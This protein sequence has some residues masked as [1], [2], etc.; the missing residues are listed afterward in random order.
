MIPP[1]EG[2]LTLKY[3]YRDG[4]NLMGVVSVR[5]R[6]AH[7][8]SQLP[9]CCRSVLSWARF[10]TLVCFEAAG[11]RVVCS[12]QVSDGCGVSESDVHR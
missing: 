2:L 4:K 10:T 1:L 11:S 9:Q 12:L 5:S 6:G 8:H 3:F 7:K